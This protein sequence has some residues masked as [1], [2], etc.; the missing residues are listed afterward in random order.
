VLSLVVRGATVLSCVEM[1]LVSTIGAFF[2]TFKKC[3]DA[4]YGS[5]MQQMF[6]L[7]RSECALWSDERERRP[8]LSGLYRLGVTL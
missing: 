7:F 2:K 3:S 5:Q 1:R 8:A 6:Y 4:H